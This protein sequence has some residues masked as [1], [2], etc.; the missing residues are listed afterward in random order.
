MKPIHA[1]RLSLIPLSVFLAG[2]PH[3]AAQVPC[4]PT[5]NPKPTLSVN[6]PE[7]RF[8]AAHTGCNPYETVLSTA[9]V[10]NLAIKWQSNTASSSSSSAVAN[11]LVYVGTAGPQGSV[12]A[13]SANNGNPKWIRQVGED[14]L[15]SPAV[16]NGVVYVGTENGNLIALNAATGVILWNYQAGPRIRSSPTVANGVVYFGSYDSK[17]YALNAA[18][19]ALLWNYQTTSVVEASPAVGNGVVVRRDPGRR[20]VRPER[21]DR[22]ACMAIHHRGRNLFFSRYDRQHVIC[23]IG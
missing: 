19:G 5:I 8:D 13:L 4:G 11:G 20:C 7:F 16:A 2:M 17:V 1:L 9:T 14:I 10:G 3:V 23:R 15:T 12:Y 6:W 22:S 18:T 21:H